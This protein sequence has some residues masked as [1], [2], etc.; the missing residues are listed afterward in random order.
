MARILFGWEFGAS[1][2]HIYPLLRIADVLREDGHEMIFVCRDVENAYDVIKARNYPLIQAPVWKN[3][4]LKNIRKIPTPSYSDVIARQGFG[5]RQKLGSML[6]AWDDLLSIVKP[7][8]IIADHSPGLSLAARKNIPMIN[9]GNGFT[10]PPSDLDRYPEIITTG[11]SLFPQDKLLGLFNEIQR[12]RGQALLEKLPQIFDTEGQFV[13]TLPQLDPYQPQ[14]NR[15]VVGPLEEN[16]DP[17]EMPIDPHI[18]VYMA[19]EAEDSELV[20]NSVQALE[21]PVTAYIRGAKVDRLQ[22]YQ[23]DRMQMLSRPVDFSEMLPKASL[24]VHS[25]G[26]GT[27]TS[28][29]MTG[30][31]QMMF[32]RQSE[33]ALT[34]RLLEHQGLAHTISRGSDQETVV[35]LLGQMLSDTALTERCLANASDI[36]KGDWKDALDKVVARAN[37]LLI[38]Q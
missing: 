8:L 30:R 32:P 26:A 35:G 29:L 21:T 27:A 6:S 17:C 1:L 37:E 3:P 36:A 38:L 10:L 4:P 20:L 24:V 12:G 14:T 34:G 22:Q 9:I 33:S 13:C 31:P 18:F 5:F 19:N 11:K 15:I 16:I 23:S 7:D 2:G 25:G 28:C